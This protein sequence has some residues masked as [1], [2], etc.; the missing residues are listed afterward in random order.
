MP[1]RKNAA[2]NNNESSELVRSTARSS[3]R[4]LS[5]STS[6]NTSIATSA[7][8]STTSFSRDRLR[9]SERSL[10]KRTQQ[11]AGEQCPH[12]DRCFGI[13]AFDRHVEWCKEK[14]LQA[15]IKQTNKTEQNK[16][17]ERLEARIKYRAPCLK[18]VC[19][20]LID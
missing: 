18:Y 15:S 16:A 17:K 13:K 8:A 19:L 20:D 1:A 2:S 11:P 10:A 12:C 14:A 6:S 5:N 7:A 3:M 9:S 4:K